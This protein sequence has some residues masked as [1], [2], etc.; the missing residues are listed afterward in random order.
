M[1]CIAVYS[2]TPR[3]ASLRLSRAGGLL[4]EQKAVVK[5][6]RGKWLEWLKENIEFSHDTASNYVKL[7]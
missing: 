7:L 2:S 5:A 6:A 4:I 1:N 3:R